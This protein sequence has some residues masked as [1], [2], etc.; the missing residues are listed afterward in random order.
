MMLLKTRVWGT[1]YMWRPPL[2]VRTYDSAGEKAMSYLTRH[3]AYSITNTSVP[4]RSIGCGSAPTRGE[5]FPGMSKTWSQYENQ[6][7]FAVS[8]SCAWDLADVV[9]AALGF[10][11]SSIPRCRSSI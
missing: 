1:F 8:D 6:A 11:S 3:D 9:M 10:L 2:S 5:M 7:F 4:G